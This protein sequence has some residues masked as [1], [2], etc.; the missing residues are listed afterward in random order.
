MTRIMG[1]K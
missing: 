1:Q